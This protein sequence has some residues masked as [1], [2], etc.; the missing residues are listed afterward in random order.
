MTTIQPETREESLAILREYKAKLSYKSFMDMH[1][2][3]CDFAIEN[4]FLN[5]QDIE[6][7]IKLDRKSV[8]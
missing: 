7:T 3:I 4:M 1:N 5:R 2:L 8:V 6:R